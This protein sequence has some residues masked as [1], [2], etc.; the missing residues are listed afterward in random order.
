V[1]PEQARIAELEAKLSALTSQPHRVGRSAAALPVAQVAPV[2]PKMEAAREQAPTVARAVETLESS[3]QLRGDKAPT[4]TADQLAA[5]LNAAE[6]DGIL[7][8]TFN[9]ANWA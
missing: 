4:N 5:L 6:A 9:R 2:N 1:T 7:S 3:L 8:K